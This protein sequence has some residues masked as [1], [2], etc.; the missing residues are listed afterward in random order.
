M[1]ILVQNGVI[2]VLFVYLTRFVDGALI[3]LFILM[4]QEVL[5]VLD[6]IEMDRLLKNHL[7]VKESITP[8]NVQLDMIATI[9]LLS[10]N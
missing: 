2:T 6:L 4:D 3:E 8:K 1:K 5:N 10:V 7:Y 9:G